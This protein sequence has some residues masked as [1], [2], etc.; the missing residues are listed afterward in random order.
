MHHLGKEN[1]RLSNHLDTRVVSYYILKK[2]LDEG[3]TI[4]GAIDSLSHKINDEDRGFIRHLVT[5]TLRRLGQLDK[6]IN[7]MTKTKLGN[8]QM[9]VRH[10]LRLGITQLLFMDVPAYAAVD[11]SVKLVET[12]LSKKLQYLKHPV[13]AILRN[14]DRERKALLKKFGNT[15]LNFP[16]WLLNSWDIRFGNKIVKDIIAVCLEEAPLDVNLKPH[17]DAEEWA[18]LLNGKVVRDNII[19]IEKSGKIKDLT[20]YNQGHWWVQDVAATLPETLLGTIK[21]DVLYDL[22]AAPGGKTAQSAARGALVTAVDMSRKRLER[23]NENMKRLNLKVDVVMSDI[24]EFKPENPADFILLDAPCSST[25]TIR[26]HPEILHIRDA[27]QVNEMAIMQSKMLE[28]VSSIMKSG[29]ILVYSVCSMQQEEGPD[30]IN[31]LL[32]K[33]RSLK[34]KEILREE[35]ND[36]E[37]A[38]LENG[39]VQTLPHF[40]EGGMDGFFIARLEKI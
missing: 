15:R 1:C 27:K 14:V 17:L 32:E 22:C 31:A 28:H 30:Q 8:T 20:G 35:L 21:G 6:I 2:I 33:D 10:V 16:K 19:R 5:T 38:I 26:R 40:M 18:N 36:F 37:N 23:L 24:L 34:R 9:A 25:G 3:M 39:D 12:K 29:S 4:E 11:G 13:N 7:H